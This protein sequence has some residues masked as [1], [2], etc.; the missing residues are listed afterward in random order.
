MQEK[1]QRPQANKV[2]SPPKASCWKSAANARMSVLELGAAAAFDFEVCFTV[3]GDVLAPAP[4]HVAR[5]RRVIRHCH[6]KWDV[7]TLWSAKSRGT[8]TK[9][10]EFSLQS[11]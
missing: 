4:T 8:C 6:L 9:S 3:L 1:E 2:Q 11:V 7:L 10:K 5:I